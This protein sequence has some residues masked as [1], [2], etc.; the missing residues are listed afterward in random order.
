M[1]WHLRYP[2]H[3]PDSSYY[4]DNVVP[5]IQSAVNFWMSQKTIK[6]N[7]VKL[8]I[9]EFLDVKEQF[10]QCNKAKLGITEFLDVDKM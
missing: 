7:K 2:C 3:L 6:R 9:T 1:N 5:C 8:G 10:I 4:A